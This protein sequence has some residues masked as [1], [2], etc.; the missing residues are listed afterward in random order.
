MLEDTDMNNI[1]YWLQKYSYWALIAVNIL[2]FVGFYI[3]VGSGVPDIT[4]AGYLA[5]DSAPE[6]WLNRPYTF[7][8]Y[9]FTQWGMMHIAF[10][11]LWL[12][13]FCSLAQRM[14]ISS[15]RCISAYFAGGICG[16]VFYVAGSATGFYGGLLAGASSAILGV[17]GMTAVL[18]PPHVKVN[19]MGLGFVSIKVLAAILTAVFMLFPWADGSAG[20]CVAHLGG[21]VGGVLAGMYFRGVFRKL[22]LR[23][24][25]HPGKTGNDEEELD[26]LLRKVQDGGYNS[27]SSD[28]QHRLIQLSSSLHNTR[29]NQ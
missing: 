5:L 13:G 20:T 7:L 28:Q 2:V 27:L 17:L 26:Q 16:A 18:A 15:V 11:M 21:V 19:L 6:V 9:M 23:H 10:N 4:V 3:A 14:G 24:T 12:W 22:L 29:K 8:T 1:G 25:I